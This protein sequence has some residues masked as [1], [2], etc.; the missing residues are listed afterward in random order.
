M[1]EIKIVTR[2]DLH[3]SGY[4]RNETGPCASNTECDR[5]PYDLVS[6]CNESCHVL[7]ALR[8]LVV[9]TGYSGTHLGITRVNGSSS[10][11]KAQPL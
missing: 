10:A 3:E 5:S 7:M 2:K 9:A 11:Y 6:H 8:V 4:E 1:Q